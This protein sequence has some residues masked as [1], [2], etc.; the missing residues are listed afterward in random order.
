MKTLAKISIILL[1]IIGLFSCELPDN[2]DPKNPTQ[3]PASTLLTN[4]E[5][6]LADQV[7]TA[8]YN[9]N[10]G[11]FLAQYW[12]EVTYLD[13]V[14]YNF[15]DRQIPDE[16]WE[17]YYSLILVDFQETKNIV[18][19]GEYTSAQEGMVKNK[20]AIV[21]ILMVYCYQNLVDAFGD[22]P[23]TEALDPD[24]V[25]P[26]YDDAKTIYQ[27]L[28]DRLTQDI[29][30]LDPNE[31]SW[32]GEELIYGGDPASWRRFAAS[33]KLRMAMRMADEDP[34]Y[35]ET[36]ATEAISEGIFTSQDQ[37]AYWEYLGTSPH[38]HSIY[39]DFVLEGRKDYVP[40]ATYVNLAESLND[41][42]LDN[43][44]T[45]ADTTGDGVP[46]GYVPQPYGVKVDNYAQ[47]SQLADEFLEPDFGHMYIDY[48][49]MRFLLAEAAARNFAVTGTAEEHYN[50]AI[51]ESV[52]RWHGTVGEANAYLAQADV[53]WATAPGDWRQ[54]I[55][56]Q[57]WLAFYNRGNEGWSVWRQFDWPTFVPP[58][59][60]TY[61]DIPERYPYPFSESTLNKENY[62]AASSKIGGDSPQ[63]LIFWDEDKEQ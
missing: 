18:N 28:I 42:R 56:T 49:E 35:A 63:T 4:A 30:D 55:G 58:P 51:T 13:E 36:V 1:M 60:F 6:A 26:A 29:A 47:V 50:A 2:V 14:Q 11:R 7:S 48:V 17:E 62:D 40:V 59:G 20:L 19:A 32:G 8:D 45:Q 21:D 39:G 53:A 10:I 52:L 3:V 27:D 24:N 22:V 34:G 41:P 31:P 5:I 12:T 16:Y 15:Q 23:Y 54:K 33:L 25:T 38:V 46:D 9:D 37:S 43:L 61:D 57:K 44:V